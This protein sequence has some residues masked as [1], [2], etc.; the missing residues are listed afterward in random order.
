M[1]GAASLGFTLAFSLLAVFV[2]AF[3]REAGEKWGAYLACGALGG[4]AVASVLLMA[5][6]FQNDFGLEYVANYSS[7]DLDPLYKFS[8]FWAGQQGSF[9]LWLLIHALVGGYLACRKKL[10]PQG[11]AVYMLLQALLAVLVLG[12]SPFLPVA[13]LMEDGVG[14]NPLLQDPWMAIHPPIIFIGYAL[15]AVPFAYGA[16][17]L[18][19]D[20]KDDGWLKPARKW[21]LIAW[22][23]LGAG[24]FI[25]GYWAYK[26]LG[27]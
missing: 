18:W 4:T 15:L 17:A 12:K 20:P 13:E 1:A 27:W 25:G 5:A 2:C 23:F 26:V 8:V 10:A 16:G 6:I 21:T 7:K 24:I 9:L 11:M 22:A 14:L 19:Q 3:R